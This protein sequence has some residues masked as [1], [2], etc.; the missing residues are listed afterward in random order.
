MAMQDTLYT[1]RMAMGSD[2]LVKISFASGAEPA[3]EVDD[4][5][6]SNGS[7]PDRDGQESHL[8]K[9]DFSVGQFGQNLRGWGGDYL[10]KGTGLAVPHIA[11]PMRALAPE[12]RFLLA[13]PREAYLSG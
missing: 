4:G 3:E 10:T 9:L 7:S 8:S 5:W 2:A 6:E 11:G 13:G 1:T 12:V